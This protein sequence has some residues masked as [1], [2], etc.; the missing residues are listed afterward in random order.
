LFLEWWTHHIIKAITQGIQTAKRYKYYLLKRVKYNISIA[1]HL[2]L[3][4]DLNNILLNT[5][6]DKAAE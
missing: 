3:N 1:I 6:W 4:F 5:E 2:T